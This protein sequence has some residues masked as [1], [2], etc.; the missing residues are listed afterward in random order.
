MVLTLETRERFLILQ[1]MGVQLEGM[2]L[3]RG[4]APPHAA[5]AILDTLSGYFGGPVI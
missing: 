2:F 5:N 3:Q 1:D 4:G